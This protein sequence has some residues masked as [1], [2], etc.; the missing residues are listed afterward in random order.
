MHLRTVSQSFPLSLVN[1]ISGSKSLFSFSITPI[2]SPISSES[3]IEVV[4]LLRG[5]W[6]EAKTHDVCSNALE[7]MLIVGF[8]STGHF[9]MAHLCEGMF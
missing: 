8:S 6:E 5:L 7:L 3:P 1:V 2:E 9:K 4:V